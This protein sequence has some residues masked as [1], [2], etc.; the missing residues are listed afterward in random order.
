MFLRSAVLDVL[1]LLT[2][3]RPVPTVLS[4]DLGFGTK[5][6]GVVEA[7][8][9]SAFW[10]SRSDSGSVLVSTQLTLLSL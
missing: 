6:P 9:E 3:L 1:I 2:T 10:D 5:A 4:S 8:R 7:G